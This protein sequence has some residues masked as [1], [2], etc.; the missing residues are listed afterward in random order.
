MN[1]R[2]VRVRNLGIVCS[3][4]VLA[5]FHIIPQAL[6]QRSSILLDLAI[7]LRVILCSYEQLHL[8]PDKCWL[9]EFNA[10]LVP[11]IGKHFPLL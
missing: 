9:K 10:E 8:Q 6:E 11:I 5:F 7:G 4:V 1:L 2:A 3:P